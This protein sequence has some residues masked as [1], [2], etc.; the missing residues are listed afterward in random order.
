MNTKNTQNTQ[1][2]L[3][4]MAN[5]GGRFLSLTLTRKSGSITSFVAQFRKMTDKSLIVRNV[6]QRKNI[7]I[8][9]R[10]VESIC[11]R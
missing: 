9:L 10:E 2:T 6:A 8:P 3:H 11:V 5:S 7:V 4:R 1:N